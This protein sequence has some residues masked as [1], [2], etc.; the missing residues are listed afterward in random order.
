MDKKKRIFCLIAGV[1]CIVGAAAAYYIAMQ[2]GIMDITIK[3]GAGCLVVGGLVF[4]MTSAKK[5]DK[6]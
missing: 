1:L 5:Q 2:T 3:I 4:L 6:E